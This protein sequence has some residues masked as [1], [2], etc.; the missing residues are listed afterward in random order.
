MQALDGWMDAYLQIIHK[1]P[2]A[3]KDMMDEHVCEAKHCGFG[4]AGY[5][6]MRRDEPAATKLPIL[7][8]VFVCC[9]YFHELFV[10]EEAFGGAL[11]ALVDE[12]TFEHLSEAFACLWGTLHTVDDR[13]RCFSLVMDVKL[14]GALHMLNFIYIIHRYFHLY[15]L[16]F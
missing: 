3:L 6:H 13:L 10:P 16:I 14:K 9:L 1:A 4:Q 8:H 7:Q 2:H 5:A 15:V 11:C 12:L